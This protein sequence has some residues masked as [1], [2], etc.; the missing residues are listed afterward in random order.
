MIT[1]V[2]VPT[3]AGGGATVVVGPCVKVVP[4][5]PER[6]FTGVQ[7]VHVLPLVQ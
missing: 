5:F 4:P 2:V 6:P 7:P 1:V 3:V